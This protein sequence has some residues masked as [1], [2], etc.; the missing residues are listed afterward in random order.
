MPLLATVVVHREIGGEAQRVSGEKTANCT[1]PDVKHLRHLQD[2]AEA[3]S[4]RP[5]AG[6][7]TSTSRGSSVPSRVSGADWQ[8]NGSGRLRAAP[9]GASDLSGRD[10]QKPLL[11]YE[12]LSPSSAPS[13]QDLKEKRGGGLFKRELSINLGLVEANLNNLTWDDQK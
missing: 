12:S 3:K 1:N 4:G 10:P 5:G 13:R 8:E 6:A 2:P 11:L 7:M 9:D